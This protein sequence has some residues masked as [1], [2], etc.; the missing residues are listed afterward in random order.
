MTFKHCRIE[1]K[2]E[3]GCLNLKK[4]LKANKKSNDQTMDK[5]KGGKSNFK[6]MVGGVSSKEQF[7]DNDKNNIDPFEREVQQYTRIV[8]TIENHIARDVIKRFNRDKAKLYYRTLQYFS[9]NEMH[10]CQLIIGFWR[11]IKKNKNIMSV[12]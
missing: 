7:E 10:N 9:V 11:A 5:I 3:I 6:N 2:E 4:K 12:D 1:L 8:N